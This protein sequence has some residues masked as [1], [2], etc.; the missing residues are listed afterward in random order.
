MANEIVSVKSIAREVLPRLIDNLVF[1][2]LIH[3]DYSSDVARGKGDSVL[4]R[5]PVILEAKDFDYVEGI[6]TQDMV[7]G[8]VEVKLD[9]LATVD[10]QM[11]SWESITE[12]DLDRLFYTPAAV[13]LAEK[14][15]RDGLQLYRDVYNTAG[16]AGVAP[17]GLDIFAE[18]AYKLDAA[19]VP[20]ADRRAVWSPAS[21]ANFRKIPDIVNAE[22]SGSTTALRSG[23]IGR[24]FGIENYMSQ[25]VARHTAGSVAD[26]LAG[27]A[28]TLTVETIRDNDASRVFL[29]LKASETINTKGIVRGD[30]LQIGG[31]N[32]LVMQDTVAFGSSLDVLLDRIFTGSVGDAVT[33][34]P[35]HE[36]GLVFHPSAFAFVTRPMI[37]PAG[38]ESYVTS[39]NGIS[40]RA[41]RGY[42][43]KMKKEIMSLDVLYGYKTVYPE[44]ALRVLG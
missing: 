21:L 9:K 33:I 29:T 26:A 42:D 40:L 22:K 35:S 2:N 4:I 43:M 38:V 24:I 31:E 27:G 5:K 19:K 16:T 34:I 11:N 15:N 1:P 28:I 12:Q 20:F 8:S 17:A 6:E 37:A 14:I 10:V 39:Y 23:S 3:T 7:E 44:L 25:A 30:I 36:A 13:A 41:T 32:Y 18:A